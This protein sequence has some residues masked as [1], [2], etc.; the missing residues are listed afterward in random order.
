MV[1]IFFPFAWL[2]QSVSADSVHFRSVPPCLHIF[3][4]W[5]HGY[6]SVFGQ[7][8]L[9][10]A[11]YSRGS[12]TYSYFPGS[13]FLCS[14]AGYVMS[15]SR[16]PLARNRPSRLREISTRYRLGSTRRFST[17]ISFYCMCEGPYCSYNSGLLVSRGKSPPGGRMTL[18]LK[19]GGISVIE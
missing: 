16:S 17:M 15:Y 13:I 10:N 2:N 12:A 8:C 4:D 1:A 11:G 9:S 18:R 3:W 6:I 5:N 19:C 14:S 7:C